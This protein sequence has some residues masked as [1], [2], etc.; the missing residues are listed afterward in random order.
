MAL[1]LFKCNSL[2]ES[3]CV[4]IIKCHIQS[5]KRKWLQLIAPPGMGRQNCSKLWNPPSACDTEHFICCLIAINKASY[6]LM[7]WLF[8]HYRVNRGHQQSC[9]Q[10]K[11]QHFLHGILIMCRHLAGCITLEAC[12]WFKHIMYI[13][14]LLYWKCL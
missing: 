1:N 5:N 8:C 7:P 13:F 4:F 12:R 10:I 11:N 3:V 9:S 2:C 6:K 14:D